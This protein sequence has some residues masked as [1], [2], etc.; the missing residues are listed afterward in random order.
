MENAEIRAQMVFARD[1]IIA[2]SLR[3]Q[4]KWAS[5]DLRDALDA[6][7]DLYDIAGSD[8]EAGWKSLKGLADLADLSY[9]PYLAYRADRAYRAY[10]ADLADRA[11]H[12]DLADR[13]KFGIDLLGDLIEARPTIDSDIVAVIDAGDGEFDMNTWGEVCGTTHCRAGW[14][15][16]LQPHHAELVRVFDY[17][18]AGAM[19]YLKSTGA[20]PNFFNTDSYAV[21]EEMRGAA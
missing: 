4:F 11:Y 15:V 14:A 13:A 17:H 9:L 3:N 12:A 5:N 18:F 2:W 6:Q 19:V 7:A 16:A 20:I 8:R 21:L 10:H 1:K